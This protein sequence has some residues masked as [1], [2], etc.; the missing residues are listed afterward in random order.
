M[1]NTMKAAVL[2]GPGELVLDTVPKPGAGP[3]QV[4]VRVRATAICGTDISMYLGKTKVNLPLIMGHEFTGTVEEIG[5]Q[6]TKVVPGDRVVIDPGTSCRV[7][8]LCCS[9]RAHL[10]RKGGLVGRE[11]PGSY[12]E[13]I[14][15]GEHQV[16]ALPEVIGFVDGAAVELLATVVHGQRRAGVRVGETVVVLGQGASGLL[17]TAL[18]KL[19]GATVVATSK[20]EGKLSLSRRYGADFVVDARDPGAVGAIQELTGGE[21]ADLVIESAGSHETVRQALELVR[22]GGRILQ[23][24]ISSSPIND[25]KLYPIYFNEITLIGSRALQPADYPPAIDLVAKGKIDVASLITHQYSLDDIAGAFKMI[26]GKSED[27]LRAVIV[28]GKLGW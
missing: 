2:Q 22:P 16:F 5:V 8:S 12:A 4:L 14:A 17:H 10:C 15:V 27:I 28:N 20:S 9:E 6:V 13:F 11:V 26:A 7:C 25:L 19:S 23:F 21:G 1:S 18:A 3:S 24:G